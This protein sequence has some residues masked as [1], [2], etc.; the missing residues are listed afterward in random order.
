MNK[1]GTRP[2]LCAV[3]Y[4]TSTALGDFYRA[5]NLAGDHRAAANKRR[6]WIVGRLGSK[7][8][9][10]EAFPIGSVPRFTA[11]RGH[12]DV[13]ILVALHYSKH[14]KGRKPSNVLRTVRDALAYPGASV[15]RNG[16]AVTLKFNSWPSVDVVPVSRVASS[17][18][19]AYYHIPDMNEEDWLPSRPVRHRKRLE[20]AVSIY[21]S[22]LRK[23][24]KMVKWWNL[25]Q[26]AP[27]E[28][29]HIEVIA[30]QAAT[31][32]GE[33]PWSLFKWF[34]KAHDMINSDEYTWY[35]DSM[36]DS[37]LTWATTRKVV[38]L[39]AEARDLA[40]AA[41]YATYNRDDHRTAITSL[42]KIFGEQFPGYG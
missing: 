41:W 7:L 23:V 3:P 34:E 25:R 27:L 20:E 4:L 31:A 36:V 11:V 19:S 6:D 38:P 39:L 32:G 24:I 10:L 42:K 9:I 8:E 13:D 28:S 16:Q 2:I 33:I 30:L 5:I 26:G 22:D 21:G 15:R 17:G 35:D 14:I 29:F 12:A 37:Y 40:Q 1:L 18:G